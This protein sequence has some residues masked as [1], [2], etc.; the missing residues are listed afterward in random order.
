MTAFAWRG[1][2]KERKKNCYFF[3]CLNSICIMRHFG[4]PYIAVV[5]LLA[6]SAYTEWL[7]CTTPRIFN[8]MGTKLEEGND[9]NTVSEGC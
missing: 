1:K 4:H 8:E 6:K 7:R 3:S 2:K 5:V 9:L